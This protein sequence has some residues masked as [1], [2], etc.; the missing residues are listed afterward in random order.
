MKQF[1]TILFLCL[2]IFFCS[3]CRPTQK[4]GG[5][6]E[7]IIRDWSEIRSR[8]KLVALTDFNS[9]DYF[10]Y[11]GQPMGYQY[12]LLKALAE[13][14]N[15]DLEIKV[16]N[17]LEQSF[18][19]LEEGDCDI[20]AIN[21]TVTEERKN[22]IR[23]TVPIGITRQVLVQRKPNGWNKQTKGQLDKVLVRNPL[24]LAGK[25]IYIQNHSSF[26]GRLRHLSDEIG[27]SIHIIEVDEEVE[28][29]IKM[30]NR[31]EIEFTVADENVAKVNHTYYSRL[32][33]STP[34]SFSQNLAWGVRKEGSEQLLKVVNAWI[35]KYKKT[36]DYALIYNKYFRN[37]KSKVRV[38][39][40]YFVLGNGRI[41]PYD[42]LIRQYSDTLRWN[43]LLLCSMIYQESHFDPKARS[44]AGAKGLMQV[45]PSTVDRYHIKDPFSPK[46]NIRAGVRYLHWLE[47]FFRDRIT[48]R[49]TMIRF[50]LAAYNTG[51]GHVLDARSLARKYGGN[52]DSWHDVRFYLL[53]LSDEKYFLDPVV[54][55]GYCRGDETVDYVEQ[56]LDRY[57]HYKNIVRE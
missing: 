7:V 24:E 41:S 33:V 19:M 21:L 51:L 13:Y 12:E 18:Q 38:K 43:W 50:V 32:D 11:R 28:K 31:G 22:F 17:D 54:K 10:I 53:S 37:P 23:F 6:K 16:N 14:L 25:T 5:N 35:L 39:S 49:D 27:D 3:G 56:I 4:D 15:I 20:L 2:S 55:Y 36:L 42:E 1:Y 57:E 47:E 34:V 44:W 26:A 30:V 45:M 8:G 40:D 48:N 29:L 9:T 52:P 46:E